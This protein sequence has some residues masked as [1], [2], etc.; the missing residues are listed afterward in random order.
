MVRSNRIVTFFSARQVGDTI[1]ID[2]GLP[3]ILI[4]I[5]GE[6]YREQLGF[7]SFSKSLIKPGDAS[8][9]YCLN[10]ISNSCGLNTSKSKL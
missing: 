2:F 1:F 3:R 6:N 10:M 8:V 7:S 9:H 5:I 4:V